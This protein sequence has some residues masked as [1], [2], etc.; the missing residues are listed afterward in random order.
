MIRSRKEKAEENSK[1]RIRFN[2]YRM[3]AMTIDLRKLVLSLSLMAFLTGCPPKT[4]TQPSSA[5]PPYLEHTIQ[6]SGETLSIVSKWYTGSADN[7]SEILKHNKG[8]DVKRLSIGQKVLIPREL[9]TQSEPLPKKFRSPL[10]WE[11]QLI[12]LP[13]GTKMF[14][15]PAF[16]SHTLCIQV[17][18]PGH[19]PRWVTPFGD[20][21]I[22]ACLAAP[23]GLS[24]PTTSFIASQYQGI[25]HMPLV[26]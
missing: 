7:W 4:P 2:S 11:S 10:L 16:A 3:E 24:Q 6:Y 23:R 17:W 19:D 13:A 20:P 8:L 18:I 26:A 5:E 25:H 9:V 22:K 21:R 12:S 14:Q 1:D 15:F